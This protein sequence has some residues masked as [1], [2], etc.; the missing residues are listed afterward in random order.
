MAGDGNYTPLVQRLRECGELALRVGSLAED[1]VEGDPAVVVDRLVLAEAFDRLTERD[2]E[3]LRLVA[4]EQLTAAEVAV[5]LGCARTTAAMR[6]SR[7][8]RRLLRAL[9]LRVANPIEQGVH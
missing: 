6:I 8:G 9:D 5:V 7:A 1:A 4:W 3:V 2:Q